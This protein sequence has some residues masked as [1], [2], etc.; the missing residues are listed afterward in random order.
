MPFESFYLQFHA[1]NSKHIKFNLTINKNSHVGI[2]MEKSVPPT[3]TKFKYFA[4]S[5]VTVLLTSLQSYFSSY[6]QYFLQKLFS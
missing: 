6:K 4:V 5:S 2:Y 1:Y 3:F